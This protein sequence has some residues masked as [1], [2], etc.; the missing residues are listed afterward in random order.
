MLVLQKEQKEKLRR[1][2]RKYGRTW[3]PWRAELKKH[4]GEG[5][6]WTEGP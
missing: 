6:E 5:R 2:I 4:K 3:E 1:L